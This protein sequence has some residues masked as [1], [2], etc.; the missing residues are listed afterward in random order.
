ML[1]ITVS[2][3]PRI[4]LSLCLTGFVSDSVI[5]FK[6]ISNYTYKT[7]E[8]VGEYIFNIVLYPEPNSQ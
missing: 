8:F 1:I 4:F 6:H 3:K 2:F 5:S 7:D